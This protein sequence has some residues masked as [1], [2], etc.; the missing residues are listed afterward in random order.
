MGAPVASTAEDT[1]SVV[2]AFVAIIFP[3][4]IIVMLVI[5]VW[6]VVALFRRRRRRKEARR[7]EELLARHGPND[8]RTMDIYGPHR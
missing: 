7:Q 5:M 1:F 2:M 4:L 8:G 6:A 3:V